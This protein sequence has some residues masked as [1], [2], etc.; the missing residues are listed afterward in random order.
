MRCRLLVFW[1]DW[2]KMIRTLA[3]LTAML[4]LLGGCSSKTTQ[5]AK[6]PETPSKSEI[7]T[8]LLQPATV[9]E[10]FHLRS[11]CVALGKKVEENESKHLLGEKGDYVV[12]T[13]TNYSVPANHCY[14][15]IVEQ[16][17]LS[18]S[19]AVYDGQTEETL[20]ATVKLKDGSPSRGYIGRTQDGRLKEAGYINASD[21]IN[22]LMDDGE[23]NQ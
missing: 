21:Y 19:T 18:K 10:V 20:A 16:H 15:L 5:P 12:L 22:R 7:E 23:P 8:T 2:L 13:R 17:G 3:G 6:E 14:V 11:E 4:L 1:R 9:T